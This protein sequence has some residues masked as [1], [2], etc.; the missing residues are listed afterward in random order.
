MCCPLLVAHQYVTEL[1]ILGQNIIEGKHSP[2][3]EPKDY[4]YSL[5]CQALT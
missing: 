1:L 3:R 4:F 2:A 5:F